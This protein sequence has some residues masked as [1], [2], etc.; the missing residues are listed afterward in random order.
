MGTNSVDITQTLQINLSKRSL[1]VF[2]CQE[3]FT[4]AAVNLA[5]DLT[6]LTVTVKFVRENF[7]YIS[8]KLR[9]LLYLELDG[10]Q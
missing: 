10:V 9:K 1:S 6:G 5:H 7:C 2:E 8:I 4:S 3:M